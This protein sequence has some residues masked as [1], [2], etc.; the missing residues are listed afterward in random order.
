M[1]IIK[2]SILILILTLPFAPELKSSEQILEDFEHYKN[3]P[4]QTWKMRKNN[5]NKYK[6]YKIRRQNNNK[7]LSASTKYSNDSIQLGLPLNQY[8]KKRNHIWRIGKYPYLS[9]KWRVKKLP[10]GGNE[11]Q[12]KKNDSA[13]GIYVIFQ[14]K[15][16]PFLSWRYQPVN[17]IKYVWS[18]TLPKGTVVK[19]TI[20]K[21]GL[22]IHGRYVVVA[23][24]KEGLNRWKTFKRNV[25]LDYIRFFKKQ[26]RYNPLMIGILTD[27][28]ATKGLA[29]ADY[30]DIIIS[31]R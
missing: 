24:G 25:L 2:S 20:K 16:I 9:W 7:Y 13:A 8:S 12:G 31:S 17:W 22:T 10:V 28:N 30:D 3:Y 11:R 27:A 29:A 21:Y 4:F 5:R 26:P 19:R 18:T 15:K 6:I 1:K 14:S 23:S